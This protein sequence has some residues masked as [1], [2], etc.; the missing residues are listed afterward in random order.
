M[1]VYDN[2]LHFIKRCSNESLQGKA[3][4]MTVKD[5][6]APL[7]IE[8]G[9]DELPVEPK[10]ASTILPDILSRQVRRPVRSGFQACRDCGTELTNFGRNPAIGRAPVVCPRCFGVNTYMGRKQIYGYGKIA[11]ESIESV[12]VSK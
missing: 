4:P 6:L 2:N 7:E 10:K 11:S 5:D 1:R 9:I 8:P 12:S 3:V